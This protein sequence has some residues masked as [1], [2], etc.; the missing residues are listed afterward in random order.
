[1]NML[2]RATY[3]EFR[4]SIRR[5]ALDKVAPY[6]KKVDEEE[7]PPIEALKASL[8]IGLPGLPFPE[9]LGGQDGDLFSQILASEELARVCAST[10]LCTTTNWLMMAVVHHGTEKQQREII[11]GI[12]RGETQ[13][14]WGLTEPKGGSDLMAISTKAIR[15]ADGWL[16]NGIKRFITNG[17]WA[18]WYLIFARTSEKE[19]SI[20]LVHKNDPGVS[21]GAKERK[22][23]MRGSPTSDVIFDDCVIPGDRLLGE[24]G[25]GTPYI[26]EAL[27]KSRLT[28]ASHAL[29]IAQGAFDEAV[30]YT[31]VREQFGQVIAR[32]QMVRGM[33]ADMAIKVESARAVLYRAVES[34]TSG[35]RDAKLLASIAKVQCS[36]AAMFVSVDAVQLHGGYGYLADYPVE[37]MMRDAKVTQIWEGTNQI[38]R[39]MISKQVYAA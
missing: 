36:D 19:F 31:A 15:T 9:H 17:G 27:L 2:D 14:A 7:R 32:H 6:A 34:F 18:D 22:M 13:C 16:L 23:G 39:L 37:R 10:A 1:M 11:P 21:F 12:S 25:Q 28:I 4:E 29:G 30:K 35:D 24:L 3:T 26:N 8:A 5:F 33:I 20:F 38:Q